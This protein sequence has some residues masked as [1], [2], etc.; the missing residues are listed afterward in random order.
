M[1]VVP[2]TVGRPPVLAFL[3]ADV[4][5]SLDGGLEGPR[6]LQLQRFKL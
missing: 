2:G 6:S 1:P 3:G 5:R 4:G